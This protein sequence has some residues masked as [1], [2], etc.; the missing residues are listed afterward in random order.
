MSKEILNP[1][2]VDFLLGSDEAEPGV[3]FISDEVQEVTMRGDLEQMNLADIFQT[4]S[5][6]KMEGVLRVKNPLETR[7]VYFRDGRCR[8]VPPQRTETRRL[9]QFL[10]RAGYITPEQLR[11]ALVEQKQRKIPIGQV[12]VEN[13]LVP[14]EE[15]EEIAVSQFTEDLFALFTWQRGAFEFY[16]GGIHD[17]VLRG[18][19]ERLPEFDV[20]S[21][22]L[23]VARRTD[24]WS[25][26][27]HAVGNLEEIPALSA[28]T[29]GVDDLPLEAVHNTVLE[30][31]N[32]CQTFRDL[33]E[34]TMLG[35]FATARACRDLFDWGLLEIISD[36]AML[37]TA[38]QWV[39]EDE[40]QRAI[41]T[42]Q[43]LYERQRNESTEQVRAMAEVLRACGEGRL[44]AG[45]LLEH[46]QTLLEPDLSLDLVRTART[47]SP[48]DREV[49]QEL[50]RQL[51]ARPEHLDERHSVLLELVDVCVN[52]RKLDEAW[53]FT[54]QL[55]EL[56]ADPKALLPRKA[57]VQ[58]RRKDER[59]A[60]ATYEEL[61][62]IYADEGDK[63]SLASTYERIL[64]L[65]H[66]RR[67]IDRA[68]RGLRTTRAT[69]VRRWAI[70]AG[71]MLVIAGTGWY[72]WNDAAHREAADTLSATV[73]EMIKAK[74]FPSAAQAIAGYAQI[75][76]TEEP[77]L[78]ELQQELAIAAKTTQSVA[79]AEAERGFQAELSAAAELLGQG[80]CADAVADYTRLIE[81][82]PKRRKEIL[83]LVDI[84]FQSVHSTLSDKLREL[85]FRIPEPPS[86]TIEREAID[87]ALATL[88]EHVP[89]S[90]VESVDGVL[91][92]E[93]AAGIDTFLDQARLEELL[94][95]ATELRKLIGTAGVRLAQYDEAKLTAATN[96]ELNPVFEAAR[97]AEA[98]H[99]F[100]AAR[101]AYARLVAADLGDASLSSHFADRLASL[102]TLTSHLDRLERATKAGD[103]DA[104]VTELQ[105][106]RRLR[107]DVPFSSLVELP[108]H[109]VSQP[110]GAAVIFDGVE[111]AKTPVL[112]RFRP[113]RQTRIEVR[114]DGFVTETAQLSGDGFGMF[115]CFL[116]GRSSWRR[117]AEGA[118]DRAIAMGGDGTAYV[119]DRAGTCTALVASTG[120]IR[121]TLPTGDLSGLLPTP[122]ISGNRLVLASIDGTARCI[123]ADS[124]EVL[125][126]AP[127][128]PSDVAPAIVRNNVLV[129]TGEE[130]VCLD[131][132]SGKPQ[133]RE[134]LGSE[135]I[136]DLQ[137]VDGHVIVACRSGLIAAI[138]P[139]RGKRIWSRTLAG[140]VSGPP[141]PTAEG[142]VA[143]V[144]TGS[145]YLLDRATGRPRWER[146][147]LGELPHRAAC[148]GQRIYLSRFEGILALSLRDGSDAG[149]LPRRGL[150]SPAT[151]VG[152]RLLTAVEDGNVLVTRTEDLSILYRLHTIDRVLT[153][154]AISHDG[155]VV[156]ATESGL[157]LG[158]QRLP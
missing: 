88:R 156:L 4:L 104:A 41:A 40:P 146:S 89:P 25:G 149:E 108:V 103:Y 52:E 24:E 31:V 123:D 83:E 133:W 151:V 63:K 144:D 150:R 13:G 147:E 114:L 137:V 84:R 19:M 90:L 11:T 39:R 58:S 10:I 5:M 7:E 67:D 75:W 49:L 96:A 145:V 78:A 155:S 157:L 132:G 82:F 18:R 86:A 153:P 20:G 118:V 106:L 115:K 17:D 12:I 29:D 80:R 28:L 15:L 42:I 50:D 79:D 51:E 125:W 54:C 117:Q 102:Q 46:A 129:A 91:A 69:R 140:T 45:L 74:K 142:L 9:G 21:L 30:A 65:D 60:I 73:R 105:T 77:F 2:E 27:L 36:E 158:F 59:G 131:F 16:K 26:I 6:S 85:P 141:T 122:A 70:A 68:L 121:W 22:L 98:E 72:L 111:I 152:E 138:H 81:A 47:L 128:L 62:E 107:R 92:L 76:G 14:S 143:V 110:A 97:A 34:S 1:E 33:G 3:S 23:E 37:D 127:G 55:E 116:A 135:A 57:V 109:V 66:E 56:G 154:S 130:L 8:C 126:N 119:V 48:R 99:R 43:T 94:S 112:T 32:G 136:A 100:H 95:T 101:D 61:A 113:D 35:L 124:G 53:G 120:E 148:D 87:T 38:E 64:K 44:A 71:A 139:T 93:N 134:N